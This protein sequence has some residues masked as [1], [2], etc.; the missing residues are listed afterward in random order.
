M[1][2]ANSSM[3]SISRSAESPGG[4]KLSRTHLF[5]SSR[6]SLM[7]RPRPPSLRDDARH[8]VECGEELAPCVALR[9]E[10]FSPCRRQFV[11]AAAALP[12]F[13]HPLPLD[14]AAFLH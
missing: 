13:L 5:Q 4:I 3:I 1:C 2:P 12:G 11:I 6:C 9:G 14:P 7:S 8:T 10:H